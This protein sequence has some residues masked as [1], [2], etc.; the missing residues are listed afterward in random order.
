MLDVVVYT[1][2]EALLR[3]NLGQE[4]MMLAGIQQMFLKM[5]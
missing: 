5:T 1:L 2:M 3:V 4:T